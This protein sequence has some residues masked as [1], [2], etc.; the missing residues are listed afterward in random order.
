MSD[1]P[2]KRQKAR[3]ELHAQKLYAKAVA[4]TLRRQ[5]GEQPW[6]VG[7]WVKK[8]QVM[9]QEDQIGNEIPGTRRPA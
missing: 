3:H 2:T 9:F 8:G 4:R 7:V 1:K 5:S 6:P